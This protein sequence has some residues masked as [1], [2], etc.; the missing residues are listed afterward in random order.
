[1]LNRACEAPFLSQNIH[2]FNPYI[3]HVFL[4]KQLHVWATS[5]PIVSKQRPQ[6]GTLRTLKL[7]ACSIKPFPNQYYMFL[8]A[9]TYLAHTWSSGYYRNADARCEAILACKTGCE[10]CFESLLSEPKKKR[11]PSVHSTFILYML[12][13]RFPQI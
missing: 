9:G 5:G 12:P 4:Y 11:T 13:T 7:T 1:M 3:Q 6:Q 2:V 8:Y 10:F